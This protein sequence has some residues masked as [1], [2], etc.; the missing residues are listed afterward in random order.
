MP[1]FPNARSLALLAAGFLL[2]LSPAILAAQAAQPAKTAQPTSQASGNFGIA[3]TVVDAISAHPLARAQV[4]VTNNN[5]PSDRQVM[6]TADDGRFHFQVNAG[7]YSLQG[8]K[9]GFITFA[10]DQHENFWTGIVTG[11][12]LDTESLTL[13]LPP[14]AA[15]TGKVT[16]DVGDPVRNAAVAIFREDHRTGVSRIERFTDVQTDDLGTYE[17]TPLDTGTYFVAVT[18]QPWYAVNPTPVN[19]RTAAFYLVDPSLDVAY[20]VAYYHDIT[21]PDDSVPIPVK[22]GDHVVADFHL[23]PVRALHLLFHTRGESEGVNVLDIQKQSLDGIDVRQD[24]NIILRSD[25]VG[26]VSGIA[27]GRYRVKPHFPLD[28][29]ARAPIEMNLTSD[30]QELDLSGGEATASFKAM[31]Q[32]H[33]SEKLPTQLNLALR[34]SAGRVV[35]RAPV[36]DKGKAEFTNVTPGKYDLLAGAPTKSYSVFRMTSEGNATSGHTLNVPAGASLTVSLSLVG[37]EATV[38]GFAKRSGKAAPG[39]MVVLVPSDPE[40]NLELFRRDQSDLDGSF[41]LAGVVPGNY[42][43]LAIENGWD[44]DW[45]KPAV[46]EPYR[47][48]GQKLVVGG[49]TK[50]SMHLPGPVE[51]QPKL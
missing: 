39:A 25:G 45:A 40:S 48:H 51:V 38:E 26:T 34:S 17:V 31:V 36:D 19:S 14:A 1:D 46:I 50:G 21:E 35:A 37:A 44:L 49:Q 10:Y 43:I 33:G 5:N 13:R 29:Q 9:R 7:K 20:P 18:A 12:G 27:P 22:G 16:D 30:G 47:Q 11:A 24:A 2:G 32:L 4:S 41:S 42:T 23:F 8:A 15:I 6:V 28:G 3:G